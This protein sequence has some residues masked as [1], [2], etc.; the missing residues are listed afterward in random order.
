MKTIRRTA[1]KAFLVL[2]VLSGTTSIGMAQFGSE[3]NIRAPSAA[4]KLAPTIFSALFRTR[5]TAATIT[6]LI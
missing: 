4:F 6:L 2:F 1:F 3:A 5:P